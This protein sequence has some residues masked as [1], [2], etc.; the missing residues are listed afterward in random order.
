[1]RGKMIEKEIDEMIE[2]MIGPTMIAHVQLHLQD[3]D[4]QVIEVVAILINI[5]SATAKTETDIEPG[6]MRRLHISTA[7]VGA[8]TMIDHGPASATIENV[9]IAIA[10]LDEAPSPRTV[11]QKRIAPSRL[12]PSLPSQP[13]VDHH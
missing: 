13:L 6:R 8:T 11:L 12:R 1:M 2:R 10:A 3:R 4:V 9:S 7:Q 5:E